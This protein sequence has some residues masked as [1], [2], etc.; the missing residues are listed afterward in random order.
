M[1]L[2]PSECSARCVLTTT[3][4]A[5]DCGK[6]T[7]KLDCGRAAVGVA[8]VG[9]AGDSNRCLNSDSII[10]RLRSTRTVTATVVTVTVHRRAPHVARADTC[11]LTFNQQASPDSGSE[12]G[13]GKHRQGL[14]P[15]SCRLKCLLWSTVTCCA[16]LCSL[17]LAVAFILIEIKPKCFHSQNE[18]VR[19]ALFRAFRATVSI[20]LS[21]PSMYFVACSQCLSIFWGFVWCC[22]L[23]TSYCSAW[24]G[25]VPILH[26]IC[27][28]FCGSLFHQLF[29][30]KLY[31][32]W[33]GA[34]HGRA[35][36]QVAGG[37][38]NCAHRLPVRFI[39]YNSVSDNI[40]K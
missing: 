5:R 27:S 18:I 25:F 39:V 20:H 26:S 32:H 13:P 3:F 33:T 40:S 19:Q 4:S 16:R 22:L 10:Q 12:A 30:R 37:I 24:R 21:I 7:F 35:K 36:W 6:Q 17:G 8:G 14:E 11:N 29:M 31:S 28:L 1:K 9:V 38:C 23:M 15:W 2:R 34:W